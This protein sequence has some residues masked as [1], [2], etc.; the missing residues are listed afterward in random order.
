MTQGG[1][2]PGWYD[3]GQGNQRWF[4]GT[5]WTDHV[6]PA[7]AAPPATPAA[8]ATPEPPA[9]PP[10]SPPPS[11]ADVTMVAPPRDLSGGAQPGYTPPGQQP[12]YTPP[13]TP[14][15]GT[16]APGGYAPVGG[17]QPPAWQNQFPPAGGS[18]GGKGK[19][20]AIIGGAVALL[21][22]IVIVLVVVLTGGDDDGGSGGG[23]NANLDTPAGVAE[24]YLAA[25]SEFDFER[26]CELSSTSETE[27]EFQGADV[28]S[29][30]A[31]GD[32]YDQQFATF[33]VDKFQDDIS[34]DVEIGDV[35]E[36]G[37]TAS[38]DYTV[39]SEYTGDDEEAFKEFTGEEELESDDD[40][41]IELVKE[42]GKWKVS[43]G[44]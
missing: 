42:D 24:A 6:Q 27:T 34:I 40:G 7:A 29:C 19:L 43:S 33:G 28:D 13:A 23:G 41:T 14:G 30:S 39:H 25:A 18:G 16:P 32:Y 10:S 3:D 38:V 36:D 37:D 35:T 4:D 12:G 21:V 11:S 22:I 44:L 1:T 26:V 8:P 5:Q 31:L 9:A 2:P 15:Y 20:I 17:A